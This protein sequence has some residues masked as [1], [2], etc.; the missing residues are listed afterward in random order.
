MFRLPCPLGHYV[1]VIQ[2]DLLAL[3]QTRTSLLPD[4]SRCVNGKPCLIHM[5]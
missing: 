5:A 2:F 3:K 1:D 4:C